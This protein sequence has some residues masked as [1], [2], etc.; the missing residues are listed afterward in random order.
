MWHN[1]LFL[2]LIFFPD[3]ELQWSKSNVLH[4]TVYLQLSILIY[5]QLKHDYVIND[6]GI[7]GVLLQ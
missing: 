2:K 1:K 5:C 3:Q 6:D 4:V 7:G